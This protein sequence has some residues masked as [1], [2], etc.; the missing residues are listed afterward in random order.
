VLSAALLV[1]GCGG[2]GD[3]GQATAGSGGEVFLQPAAAQ[4][5]DPFTASSARS[6][7]SPSTVTR[8]PQPAPS[9]SDSSAGARTLSGGTPGLYGGTESVGS[10]DVE[11]QIGF[12]TADRVKARAFADVSGISQASVPGY[13]RGM[14]P[15]V[16]RADTKVTNHGFRDGRAT[17]YQSVLQAGT[18][19]LVDNRGVPR[20]R[21]ACGNPLT[22]PGAVKGTPGDHGRPWPGYRPTQVIVVTPAP[23]VIANITI[24]NVVSNTWIERRIGDDGHH[25]HV[26]PPPDGRTRP[27]RPDESPSGRSPHEKS[28]SPEES[29]S[30]C[31]TPTATVTVTPGARDGTTTAPGDP[32][33]PDERT[34]SAAESPPTG[35]TPPAKPSDC[36]TATVTAP[37]TGST[38][39]ATPSSPS[40]PSD[41][42]AA[43][44]TTVPR[45]DEPSDSPTAT[46]SAAPADSAGEG[47]TDSI[48]GNPT[49]I[50]DG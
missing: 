43:P 4:G 25:D 2:A 13:L 24:I 32:A 38:G 30:D 36:P 17:G 37:P 22:A 8:T 23:R 20:V 21:C 12:L 19:V 27:P 26:V 40:S 42:S 6:T 28:P 10:C 45:T 5:P 15:V 49:G 46:E 9:G 44:D 11:K 1:A 47:A 3:Q 31:V 14:T 35:S 41:R 29:A 33:S 39:P 16:L 34:S 50:F 48:F 7:E 18:A